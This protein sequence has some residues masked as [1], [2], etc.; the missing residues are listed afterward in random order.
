MNTVGLTRRGFSREATTALRRAFRVL[1]QSRLN[2]TAAL[3]ELERGEMTK[4]V[5]ELVAFIR[6]S[7]RGVVLKRAR[8]AAAEPGSGDD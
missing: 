3:E 2:T 7:R 8:S 4:E 1:L 5:R 6:S